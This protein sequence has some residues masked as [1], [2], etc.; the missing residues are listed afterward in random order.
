MPALSSARG[1]AVQTREMAGVKQLMVAYTMY[2]DQNKGSVMPGYPKASQVVVRDHTGKK[3]SGPEA[4]RYPWRLAPFLGY[5]FRGLYPNEKLLRELMSHQSSYASYGLT[6]EYFVSLLPSLGV[7]SF[8]VGGDDADTGGQFS[9]AFTKTFGRSYISRLDQ[10]TRPSSL[11]TFVSA[12]TGAQAGLE[13]LGKPEGYFK[14]K[15]PFFTSLQGRLWDAEYDPN[16]E[17]PGINSGFVSLRHRGKA[18]AGMLDT[19]AQIMSWND[20]NDMRYWSDSADA[21]DWVLKPVV[22]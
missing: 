9:A 22:R 7:N 2:A 18:V 1:A 12:R 17:Y 20:L 21:A 6:Y 11:M 15:P 8:F 3:L 13:F 5:D 10:A 19:H 14:V 16:A 4:L